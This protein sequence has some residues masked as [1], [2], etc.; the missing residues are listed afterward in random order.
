MYG[1]ACRERAVIAALSRHLPGGRLVAVAGGLR[2]G[3]EGGEVLLAQLEFCCRAVLLEVGDALRAGDGQD[4]LA[5]SEGP[6]D[7]DLGQGRAVAPGDPPDDRQE[8]L[9][10]LDS[11]G[12][13]AR[14]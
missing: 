7:R 13:E 10:A 12:R 9:V 2:H 8:G 6:G 14:V 11:L 1:A 3:V 4:V 5:L